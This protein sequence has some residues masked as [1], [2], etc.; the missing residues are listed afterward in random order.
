MIES[1]GTREIHDHCAVQE[2][3]TCELARWLVACCTA[4]VPCLSYF[5]AGV[6]HGPGFSLVYFATSTASSNE[7]E[8]T[9]EIPFEAM[10][11]P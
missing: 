1:R 9:F 6:P 10:V 8:S 4:R 11:T 7:I 5:P 3:R 2:V